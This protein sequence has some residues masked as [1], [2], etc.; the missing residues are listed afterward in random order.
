MRSRIQ[1]DCWRVLVAALM[2]LSAGGCRS[3]L[4]YVPLEPL[5][6]GWSHVEDGK[7]GDVVWRAEGVTVRAYAAEPFGAGMGG[8]GNSDYTPRVIEMKVVVTNEGPGPLV[9]GAA[10]GDLDPDT[11]V[12]AIDVLSGRSAFVVLG[13]DE[14]SRVE[15]S[16]GM[17]MWSNEGEAREVAFRVRVTARGGAA[18]E[19]MLPIEMRILRADAEMACPAR[20]L[21]V[22]CARESQWYTV[23]LDG[24]VYTGEACAVVASVPFAVLGLGPMY[25]P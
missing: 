2:L 9:V 4:S 14:L 19:R 24:L 10:I 6:P 11:K 22:G 3:Y 1:T 8:T 20:F 21:A 18:T 17:P 16:A 5:S 12:E 15:W 23:P 13:H 25:W 7:P